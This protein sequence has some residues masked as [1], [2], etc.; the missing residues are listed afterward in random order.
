MKCLLQSRKDRRSRR[1]DDDTGDRKDDDLPARTVRSGSGKPAGDGMSML[2]PPSRLNRE[3][4]LKRG[5]KRIIFAPKPSVRK[6]DEGRVIS[7][8]GDRESRRSRDTHK[9]RRVA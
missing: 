4:P 2:A 7:R 1:N 3:E 6:K 9:S 8:S 5:G